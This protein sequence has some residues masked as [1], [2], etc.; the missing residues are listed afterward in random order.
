MLDA[1]ISKI[2]AALATTLLLSA[3]ASND[4]SLPPV[5]QEADT[6]HRFGVFVWHELLTT[7]PDAA[8]RFYGGLFGWTFE[9]VPAADG[10]TYTVIYHGDR[11][12]G[13]IVDAR[14]FGTTDNVSQWVPVLSISDV[15]AAAASTSAAGGRVFSGPVDV[16]GRG[17]IA[18]LGDPQGGVIT[19]L[20]SATGD[21]RTD[22]LSP[23]G[24]VWNEFWSEDPAGA[25][26]F[27]SRLGGYNTER[28]EVRAGR[29]YYNLAHATV[30]AAGVLETPVEGIGA[31]WV[32]YVGVRDVDE[33]VARVEALGGKVII[34]TVE[35]V[36]NSDAA[37]IV[38]P[39]GAGLM[40]QTWP[41]R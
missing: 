31:G 12:V 19:V 5:T 8:K 24:F 38:D 32:A 41:P 34:D 25:L 21:P 20:R 23:G 36:G 17:R 9:D 10:E 6:S 2:M 4:L 40:L 11:P 3:C 27:Y 22:D 26:A 16:E 39:S 29:V 33:S 18:V 13:G 1:S 28:S 14:S 30:A 15:D 37:G 7:D 35:M